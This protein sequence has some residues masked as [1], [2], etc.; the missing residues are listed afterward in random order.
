MYDTAI[1]PTILTMG[2]YITCAFYPHIKIPCA[3]QLHSKT[4]CSRNKQFCLVVTIE[5][6][7]FSKINDP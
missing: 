4:N 6:Q 1:L 3:Y 5:D 2:T 7:L